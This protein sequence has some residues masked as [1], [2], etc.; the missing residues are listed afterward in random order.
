MYAPFQPTLSPSSRRIQ[1]SQSIKPLSLLLCFGLS[2]TAFAQATWQGLEF[3]MDRQKAT[4]VLSAKGFSILQGG[5][6]RTTILTPDF[7]L[8][9]NSAFLSS[10]LRDEV[11]TAPMFLKPEL[12]FDEHGKLEIVNL[13]LDQEHTFQTTPALREM[14]PLLAFIAGTSVYEQLTSKYGSPA[15]SRG[16]CANIGLAGL[17]GSTT[18]CTARWNVNHQSIELHWDYRDQIHKLSFSLAYSNVQ[19]AL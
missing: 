11:A 17:V 14:V 4:E 1:V 12:T 2:S 3:G 19:S 7:E 8:K 13:S 6:L 5:D 15:D 9:T 16:R 18:E 10:N